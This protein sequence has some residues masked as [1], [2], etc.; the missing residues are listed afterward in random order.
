MNSIFQINT[1]VESKFGILLINSK[2]EIIVADKFALEK[3]GL[4]NEEE[5]IQNKSFF[6][7]IIP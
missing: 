4:Q 2:G 5:L 1:K 7:L 6:N 3:L